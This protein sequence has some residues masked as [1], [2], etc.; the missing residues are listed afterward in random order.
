MA[1]KLQ[2]H[3]KDPYAIVSTVNELVDGRSN[4]CGMVEEGNAVTLKPGATST[5]VF[6]AT[7]STRSVILLSPRTANA[8]AAWSTTY[9]LTKLNGS[10]VVAHLNNAQTDRTFDFACVGG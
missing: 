8:S 5:T 7:M 9:I 10:F 6:F 1:R 3:E 4:N 2:P